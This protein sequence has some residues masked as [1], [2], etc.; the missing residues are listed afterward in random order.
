MS[1]SP[2]AADG[3]GRVRS[4]VPGLP[5]TVPGWMLRV[6]FAAVALP[7]ALTAAPS[8]PWPVLCV[9]LV[10]LTIAMPRWRTAWLLVAVLAFSALLEPAT[11]VSVRILGLIAGVHALHLLAAW[12]LAV[13]ARARL[14]PAALLPGARRFLVVQVPAQAVAVAILALRQPATGG[15]SAIAAGIAVLALAVALGTVLLRRS[16]A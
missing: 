2:T 6:A 14:Q 15:L 16:R 9:V 11:G 1:R 8:G 12:M 13:P 5:R 10:S 4:V 3:R 7:L